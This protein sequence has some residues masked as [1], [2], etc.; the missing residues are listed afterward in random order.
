MKDERKPLLQVKEL[1]KYH[2]EPIIFDPWANPIEV[3]HEYEID[4]INKLPNGPFEAA[5]LAVS[6]D[7]F[8]DLDIRSLLNENG[9][10][11]DVKGLF[12]KGIADAR[13]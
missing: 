8:K 13:L 3:Y 12:K 7:E 5:I 4:V 6:H 10:L 2:V 1:K 9:V 11:F